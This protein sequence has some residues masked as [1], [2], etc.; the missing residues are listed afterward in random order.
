MLIIKGFFEKKDD[1]IIGIAS[2][3]ES[4]RDGEVILQDGWE[5]DPF[6][7]NPVILA[8]HD[9]WSF[10][11]GKATDLLIEGG[12]LL[13]KMVFATTEKGQEALQL[14]KEGVLNAFSVGF[15]AKE[16]A[17]GDTIS[18]A[19]LLEISLVSVPANPNAVVLAK[20]MKDNK[21]AKHFTDEWM[22]NKDIAEAVEAIE[23]PEPPKD[24]TT[25]PPVVD[26]VVAEPVT[27]PAPEEKQV[28]DG[29]TLTCEC[30]KVYTLKFTAQSDEDNKGE[31]GDGRAAAEAEKQV[32]NLVLGALKLLQ[33]ARKIENREEDRK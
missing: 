8:G 2:T 6:R 21:L 15:I 31:D 9:Y 27:P 13:F 23:T 10:P 4:D 20:G 33:K 32:S 29:E 24:D 26:P 28:K 12:R 18:R 14:V 30:G 7:K 22:K 19:E 17:D 1:E 16:W 25:T 3:Q 5:L 11:I